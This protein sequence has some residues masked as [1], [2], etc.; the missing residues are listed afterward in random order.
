MTDRQTTL[1]KLFRRHR[2]QVH[3]VKPQRLFAPLIF[4]VNDNK[5]L[6]S[7]QRKDECFE[8]ERLRRRVY[9]GVHLVRCG[10]KGGCLPLTV[11][12]SKTLS[13]LRYCSAGLCNGMCGVHTTPTPFTVQNREINVQQ[14]FRIQ[15]RMFLTETDFETVY[16]LFGPVDSFADFLIHRRHLATIQNFPNTLKYL[17]IRLQLLNYLQSRPLSADYLSGESTRRAYLCYGGFYNSAAT[18]ITLYCTV[19]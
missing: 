18:H 5:S 12:G 6:V 16:N 14:L 10:C 9:K 13:L 15:F 1:Q 11:Q 7:Q 2:H 3:N 8:S 19:P 4:N 17:V